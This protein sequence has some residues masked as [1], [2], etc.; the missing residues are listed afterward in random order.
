NAGYAPNAIPEQGSVSGTIRTGDINV[1]R[2]IQ[3]L[4]EEL[5]GQVLAPTDCNFDIHYTKGVP[6]VIN[7]D[8]ATAI[9]A[10]AAQTIGPHTVV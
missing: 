7:D 10:D 6:P 4:L 8:V 9:L 2:H 1:W 3:P 5:V